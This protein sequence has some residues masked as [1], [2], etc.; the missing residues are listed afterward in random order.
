MGEAKSTLELTNFKHSAFSSNMSYTET[1]NHSFNNK[2]RTE[3]FHKYTWDFAS[4]A[5][6]GSDFSAFIPS[7]KEFVNEK[8]D[9]AT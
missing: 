9:R 5:L 1:H 7:K 8:A 3:A 2:D 4:Q 6:P